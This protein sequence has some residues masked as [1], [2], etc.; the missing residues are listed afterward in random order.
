MRSGSGF[1]RRTFG[2][3]VTATIG[4]SGVRSAD[5]KG[6][7]TSAWGRKA[8]SPLLYSHRGISSEKLMSKKCVNIIGEDHE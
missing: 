1:L 4:R 5:G 3:G 8:A 2:L 7:R 6:S